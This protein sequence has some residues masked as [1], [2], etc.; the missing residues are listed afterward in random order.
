T[1]LSSE[2]ILLVA[3]DRYDN[4]T[5]LQNFCEETIN[6]KRQEEKLLGKTIKVIFW[7]VCH[8]RKAPVTA[9]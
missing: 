4:L 2:S 9:L 7:S 1:S 3:D 6:W 5:S 8:K